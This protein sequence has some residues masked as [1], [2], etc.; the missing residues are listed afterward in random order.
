MPGSRLQSAGERLWVRAGKVLYEIVGDTVRLV[1][2]RGDRTSALPRPVH[3]DADGHAWQAHGRGLYLDGVPVLTLPDPINDLAVAADGSLWLATGRDGV[4]HLRRRIGAVFRNQA[5]LADANLYTVVGSSASNERLWTAGIGTGLIELSGG[6]MG[7]GVPSEGLVRRFP[8]H[9]M[10]GQEQ[11]IWAV[12]EDRDGAVWIG[13]LSLCRIPSGNTCDRSGLPGELTTASTPAVPRVSMIRLLM[14]DAAGTVWIGGDGGL[15]RY[16]YNNRDG[17]SLRVENSPAGVRVG[18]ERP[19]G[20]IWFGTNGGGLYL[21][22]NGGLRKVA[23]EIASTL[24]RSL[25]EDNDGVL[26]VGTEDQ[27]LLRLVIDDAARVV[28]QRRYGPEHG[29]WD[30]VIHYIGEDRRG[31]LWMNSNRGIFWIEREALN[32]FAFQPG[33]LLPVVGYTETNGLVNREGNGGVHHAGLM[34]P[35]GTLWLPGQGGLIRIDTGRI[36]RNSAIPRPVIERARAGTDPPLQQPA[37]ITLGRGQRDLSVTYTA[38]LFDHVDRVR[39]RYRLTGFES[40]WR[41]AGNRREAFYTNLPAGEFQF[42]VMARSADGIWSETPARLSVSVAPKFHEQAWFMPS[43]AVV[44]LGLGFSSYRWRLRNLRRRARCLEAQVTERTRNLHDEQQATRQALAKVAS[45]ADRLRELDRAKSRFFTNLSHELRTPLTLIVGP[46]GEVIRRLPELNPEQTAEQMLAIRDNGERLLE[47]VNQIQALSRLEA[48]YRPLKTASGDLADDCRGVLARF[49]AMADQRR[50]RLIGP[51]SDAAC[52]GEFDADA[53]DKI[54]ANLLGN[55]LRH[56]PEGSHVTLTLE[57]ITGGVILRVADEGPGIPPDRL[58]RIFERFYTAEHEGTGSGIGLALARELA[59]LHG[60]DLS[61]GN[62]PQ[63][64]SIFSLV[65]PLTIALWQTGNGAP[66]AAPEARTG[67]RESPGLPEEQRTTLLVVED[68]PEVRRFV[69]GC[70]GSGYRILEA[71]D[72]RT[73][74]AIAHRDLPDLIISDI[75]MPDLDGVELSRRLAADP[76]TSSIPVI[77]LTARTE[78][79]DELEGLRAGAIDYITKPFA[80]DLLIA[81]VRRLLGFAHRLRGQI[82]AERRD[83][84]RLTPFAADQDDL[85]TRLERVILDRLDDE[86]LDV[87]ALAGAIHVSRSQLKRLMHGAGLPPPSALIRSIRLRE[88]ARLL[89]YGRGNVSEVAYAVGFASLSH[90]SRCFREEFGAA[91]TTW[92]TQHRDTPAA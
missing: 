18:L 15:F 83:R 33:E 60:G 38:A 5:L 2:P 91:P 88:A 80:P 1:A 78:I 41:E 31:R 77:L 28:D 40:I 52:H 26:W 92:I 71:E 57:R 11:V 67:Q 89:Q 64:G 21:W 7:G 81:R 27:G 22:R 74:L 85:S 43:L 72:G 4:I 73:G 54:L 9:G 69:A 70:L 13:G 25:Y 87:Q 68:Q 63:G 35:D 46:A 65:L 51:P 86:S 79:E 61:V 76:V 42:E 48:G 59:R 19:D 14:Q 44:L 55:A 50:I 30:H 24:L 47:L 8:V 32:A 29:L 45:Q 34:M 3:M 82:R 37:A 10:Y 58:D 62:A 6:L 53:I 66:R 84:I 36:E 16:R 49:A 90:F 39:F 75:M 56:A 12:L 23:G 20:G 17:G